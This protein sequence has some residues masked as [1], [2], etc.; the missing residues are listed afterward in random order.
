MTKSTTTTYVIV[1]ENEL[2][3]KK[4]EVMLT[5]NDAEELLEYRDIFLKFLD[6]SRFSYQ[7]ELSKWTYRGTEEKL[8]R[9]METIDELKKGLISIEKAFITFNKK[10]EEELK[11]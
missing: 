6:K 10:K 9:S 1:S 7:I 11:K 2:N 8:Y 4:W 5:S 3:L